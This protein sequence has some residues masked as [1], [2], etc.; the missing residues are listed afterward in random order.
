MQREVLLQPDFPKLKLFKAG[1]VREIYDVGEH[2][3]I[4]ATDRISA[5]DVIMKQGIPYKG[6]VLNK[7][8]E[9]WFDFTNNIIQN[10]LITTDINKYP[11][12]YKDYLSVLDSR[13]MLVNKTKVIPI[14]CIV[15]GYITGSGWKDYKRTCMISGIKLSPRLVESE[16]LPEPIFTP[17]TKAEIGLHDENITSDRASNIIGAE[18][19]NII[20]ESSLKIYNAAYD[21]ALSKGI[22]IAD[23]KFEF[24]IY[25]G[26][27][28]LI[29]EVLTPD[30]SRFWPNDKYQKGKAQE[31]F[32]KQF[33]RD[34]LIS[35][36][37]NKQPPPPELPE[38]VIRVTSEKYKEAL[39]RL[40]GKKIS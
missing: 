23:T 10:H 40:T 28:I 11:R 13:S 37:F 25:N 7:I 32:D 36:G 12:K 34:Y 9:F 6:I 3:L 14:E 15:R 2:Y 38:D 5:F 17:S 21:F 4:V 31:S 19:F 24:G 39:Y 29:D 26:E 16:K 8:S 30:S 35:I 18:I 33:V 1:K 27:I 22:I 20:K